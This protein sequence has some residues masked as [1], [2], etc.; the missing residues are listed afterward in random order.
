MTRRPTLAAAYHTR[1]PVNH[2]GARFEPTPDR[3]SLRIQRFLA[4]LGRLVR[5]G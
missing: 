5:R 1:P 3:I 2:A 4:P